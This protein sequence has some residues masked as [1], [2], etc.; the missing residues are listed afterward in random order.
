MTDITIVSTVLE[1]RLAKVTITPENAPLFDD[2]ATSI[3]IDDEGGGEFIVISQSE[4]RSTRIE[5]DEWPFLREA[6]N[7][8]MGQIR[9]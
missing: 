5:K 2:R 4:G 1:K 7:E 6:I 3:E 9:P 8:M